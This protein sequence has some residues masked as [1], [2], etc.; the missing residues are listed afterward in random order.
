MALSSRRSGV[1]PG[2]DLLIQVGRATG[3]LDTGE[4]SLSHALDVAVHGILRANKGEQRGQQLL[5]R[6]PNRRSLT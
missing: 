6:E 5:T 1:L 3:G 4:F 2:L